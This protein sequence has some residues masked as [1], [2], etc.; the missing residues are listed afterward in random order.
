MVEQIL[1]CPSTLMILDGLHEKSGWSRHIL[2]ETKAGQ[3]M[4]L[5]TSRP[6]DVKSERRLVDLAVSHKGLSEE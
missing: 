5:L 1:D 6:Y 4:L 2:Q 3:H